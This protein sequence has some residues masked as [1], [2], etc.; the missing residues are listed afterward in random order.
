MRDDKGRDDLIVM[1]EIKTDPSPDLEHLYKAL[2][3][4]RIGVEM[5]I[6][7]YRPGGL[8]NLTEVEKRQK[9]KRLA[10]ERFN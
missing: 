10:D 8:A 2:L 7:F 5:P 6:E 1:I 4:S 3:K 9:P